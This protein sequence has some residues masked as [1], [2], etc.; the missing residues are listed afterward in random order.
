MENGAILLLDEIDRGTNKIMCLQGILEGRPF[1]VK[2][3]G[4]II[5][6]AKGFNIFATANTQGRGSIDGRFNAASILDEAFLE[7]F[8][9]AI[10]QDYPSEAIERR[11][12]I[13]HM[14]QFE[15]EKDEA[16]ASK[17]VK[18]SSVIRK[19]YLE[20]GIDDLIS[21]RRLCH[22]VQTYSIFNDELKAIKMCTTRFE[23]E[24]REAFLDLYE[25]LNIMENN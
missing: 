17:L 10:E 19:T 13:N 6:P 14:E 18:W 2:K 21:T 12:L 8:T 7:R 20:E 15:M 25:K 16:L 3:T 22:I 5:R 23:A 4:E 9:V 1:L 11:I 24:T